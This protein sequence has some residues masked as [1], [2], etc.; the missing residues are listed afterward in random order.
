MANFDLVQAIA[1]F[2]HSVRK[3]PWYE[4]IWFYGKKF[5]SAKALN[6]F[7]DV[8]FVYSGIQFNMSYI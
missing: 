3:G 1:E 2:L 8:R 7:I 5:P 6:H 4:T